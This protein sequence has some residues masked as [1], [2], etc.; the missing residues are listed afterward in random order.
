MF[1]ITKKNKSSQQDVNNDENLVAELEKIYEFNKNSIAMGSGYLKGNSKVEI[2]INKLL[3][4]KNFQVREQFHRNCD[5]IEF[6]TQMEYVKEMVD[7]ISLQ[8]DYVAEVAANGEEMSQAIQGIAEHVQAALSDTNDAVITSSS[9][10][11]TISESFKYSNAS[12]DEINRVNS[13]MKYVAESTKEI[14]KVVNLIKSVS[15][16]TNL[17]ALNASIEAARAG[18]SGRGFAVVA[19]EIKKLADSTRKSSDYISDL[20]KNLRQEI[21]NLGENIEGTVDI[22]SNS[23][24]YIDDSAN[25]MNKI[26]SYIENIGMVFE[27]IAANV[28]QQSAASEEVS[29]NLAEINE[30]TQTLNEVCL[31]TA[32]SIYTI[33]TMTEEQIINA[34]PYFK[35]VNENQRLRP[36]IAEHLLMKWKAYNAACGFVNIDEN[37]IKDHTSCTYGKFLEMMKSSKAFNGGIEKQYNVHEKV[38]EL[39]KGIIKSLKGGNNN[40][41]NEDLRELSNF[42]SELTKLLNNNS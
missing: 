26:K 41:I 30:N 5:I 39:T 20:V 14:D 2:A 28:E 38:H 11:K 7:N 8:K 37:S 34:L 40:K 3:E 16:Q 36:I 23:I 22:F 4:L 9:A 24:K 31:R 15:E 17:L 12:F 19:N 29:V 6:V 25:S 21:S 10:I 32:K 18:E 1:N 13:K 42:V 33:S 35:D 27:S